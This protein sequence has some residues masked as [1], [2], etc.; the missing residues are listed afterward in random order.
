MASIARKNLFED[1]PRFLAAQ[2]GIM[3]AVSLV[4]IQTGIFNGFT[5]A[6]TLLIDNSN[7]D[8]WVSSA[9]MIHMELTLPIPAQRVVEARRVEGVEQAEPLIVQASLWRDSRNKISPMRIIGFNPAGELFSPGKVIQGSLSAL[10]QPYTV[11]LDKSN[12]RPLNIKQI[13]DVAEVGSFKAQLVA[14]TQDTQSITSNTFLFTSLET[15]NAYANSRVTTSLNCKL[16]SGDIKCTSA[17]ASF[18]NPP[19]ANNLSA[20]APQKLTPTDLITYVLVQAKPGQD[21]QQLKKKLEAALPDTRAYTKAEMASQTRVFWQQRTGIGFI[22]G[23]GAVVGIIIGMAIAGQILYASVSDHLKEYGTLKAMGASDWKIYG[24]IVEQALWM[25]VLGYIPSMVLCQGLGAWT[26]A[27][28]GIII[29]IT[30]G[31][32]IAIFGITT[33]MCVG[34]AIFAIQRVTR[35]DPAI[36]FKA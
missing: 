18:N 16:Q 17:S 26:F 13:G 19:A 36:V 22:L 32:A 29:L 11:M 15:A 8:I 14:L 27:T 2:A 28:Q 20:P 7:A 34:S 31:S 35:V 24:V 12:L 33:L 10:K 21:L 5:R 25:A 4:T 6:T 1:I 3:F 9:D 23:L 30:P